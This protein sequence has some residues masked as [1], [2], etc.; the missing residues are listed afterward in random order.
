[1]IPRPWLQER[2]VRRADFDRASVVSNQA[3]AGL[4]SGNIDHP[5]PIAVAR[6][7]LSRDRVILIL[8]GIPETDADGERLLG[9]R[10]RALGENVAFCLLEYHRLGQIGSE[11]I[12]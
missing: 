7:L 5:S 11:S 8:L 9:I 4:A 12:L 10:L 1:M 6:V 2:G 3:E